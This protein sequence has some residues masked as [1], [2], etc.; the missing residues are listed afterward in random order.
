MCLDKNVNH[1]SVLTRVRSQVQ[2]GNEKLKEVIEIIDYSILN[3]SNSRG[4][5]CP[6]EVSS[7][8]KN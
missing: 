6:M 8:R 2:L 4:L 5:E 7:G 1:V 3:L